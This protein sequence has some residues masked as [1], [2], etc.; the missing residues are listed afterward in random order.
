MCFLYTDTG[1]GI[2]RIHGREA[3]T[4]MRLCICRKIEMRTFH[5]LKDTFSLG[6]VQKK[7]LR[8]R[9]NVQESDQ[10]MRSVQ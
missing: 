6:T 5:M 4:L 2:D 8:T 10:H 3:N 1:M 7:A 9:A